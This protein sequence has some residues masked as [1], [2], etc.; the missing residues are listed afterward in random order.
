PK[1]A[2]NST[3]TQDKDDQGANLEE[4]NLNKEHFVLPI[5]Y[6]YSTTVK[7]SGDKIEK[8]ISFK[9]CEKPNASTSSTNL[10]NNAST[11]L[12]TAGPSRAFNNGELSYLNP[13]KYA[14]PDDPSVPHLEDIYVSLSKGVFTDSSCD[15]EG[16]VTD[17]NNLETTVSVILTL[18]TRIHTIHPKTQILGNPKSVVQTRSKVNK[19]FEARAL[20]HMQEEEI[21]YDEVFA[22]VARIKAIKIFLAF[23]SYI[24]FIVYQIDVKS[25]FLYGTIN[26]E[27]YV[28]QPPGFVDPKFPNKVNKVV[29]ALYGLHQAPRAWSMIGSLMYLTASR[30]DIMFA[31]SAYS[32]FQTVIMLVQI[33]TGNPQH[34]VVNFLAGDLSHATLV[35]RR[36]IEEAT[37]DI[38]NASTSSTNLIN[39]ASTPLSTA[40]PSRAFN[41]GELS[42]LNP[43]KY[44]LPDD[45]SVPHLEDIYVSLSK[46]VFTDSS[47]DDEGMVTDFNN[48]ETTVSVILTLTTRIHTIHPKTQILGNPKSVVQTRSKVNKNFEARALGHMQEEE[49]DYDEVFAPVARIKAI[50]IFLAFDSYIGFI[51]YQ[52]DVKSV[53]L[54]GTINEEVYVSQPP[55][56]VDPKFPNK[57][58]KVVKALYGLHQAP[59]AWYTTLSTFLEK[60]RYRREAIDKTLFIKKDKKDI[61]LVQVY[62]DDIIFTKP[63]ESEGFEQILNFLNGSSVS[64]A[65]TASPTIRTSCIKQFW[66]IVEVKTI[67]DLVRIQA[68][69]DENRLGDMS[70]HK[71]IYDNLSLKKKVS[72]NMKK[73]GTGFSRVVTLLFDNMLVPAAKE[74][75]LI[76]DDVQLLF[77]PNK[78][79][80][81]KPYKKHKTKKHQ[82]QAPKVPSTEPSPEHRLPLPS[83]DPLPGG[84]DSLKL[85]ELMDLCTHLS[86][87]VLELESEVIDIKSTYKERIDKLK[88]RVDKLEEENR[89]L[90]D[91]YSVHSKVDTAASIV[92]KEKSFKQRRIIAYIDENVEINLE[93]AQAKLYRIDLEHPK[94]VFSMQDVNDEEP[95]EVEEVLEVVTAANEVRPLFEK[96]YNYNQDFLKEVNEEVTVPEKEVKVEG[97]KREGRSLEK[98]ITK[99][100]KMDEEAEELKSEAF[101]E[102]GDFDVSVVSL[103]TC[104]TDILGFLEKFKGGFE[105][106][107]DVEGEE[108]KEDEE[109]ADFDFK[110]DT[111]DKISVVM[112]TIDELECLNPRDEFDVSNDDYSTFM[113]KAFYFL[114]AESEDTIFDPG[115]SV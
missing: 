96:H 64:Y 114:S 36:I 37:H 8:N 4:I 38:Q 84:K 23:D 34:E 53:F 113:F 65:L 2:N 81:S 45:P 74:V 71:N 16:M 1:E 31:V 82:T 33:L 25:V 80:T 48:L 62:V 18:T 103:Q 29:K 111:G 97:H 27:V 115:I 6:A 104:L 47:C 86:N 17:F 105:Q 107:I 26:E 98:E 61:M 73:V 21:D 11:P 7:S 35:K 22:P 51:V 89:V 56:F 91:L 20:G 13:S 100:Q 63:T 50:K 66:P 78:P 70:Y 112:N 90:K 99:K 67:N 40:G 68:L 9:T 24:G 55:G 57:V 28:S 87:K 3:G 95:A 46:G 60:S 5:L 69:I 106:D 30:P 58:N 54:Y 32:R 94:K 15:D 49:I 110:L 10:I 19:N 39:N 93:E 83:N 43:S 88:G 52:I 79:S 101:C 42:Y 77:I 102:G 41:N 59:R 108:D 72:A 44:A 76:Q 12:S 92:E 14:L 75:G 109:D 85:K